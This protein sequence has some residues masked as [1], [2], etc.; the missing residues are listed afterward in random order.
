M[1]L[2][3]QVVVMDMNMPLMDGAQAA[4]LIKRELPETTVIGLSVDDNS[5][6]RDAFI[7]REQ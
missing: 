7:Q 4:R 1:A 6:V 2:K 3:P 5:A